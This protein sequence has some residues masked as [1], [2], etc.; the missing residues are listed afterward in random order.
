MDDGGDLLRLS[1]PP[2]G[3]LAAHVGDLLR[4]Q[5]GENRRFND[6]RSDAVDADSLGTDLFGR[7]FVRQ[8]TPAFETE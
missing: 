8:M 5:L 1:C 4:S 6:G 3:Y 2:H 7:A